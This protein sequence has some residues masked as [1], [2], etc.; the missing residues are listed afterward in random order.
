MVGS[1]IQ[2]QTPLTAGSGQ[3]QRR[4]EPTTSALFT[5]PAVLPTA[6]ALSLFVCGSSDVVHSFD[7]HLCPV[8][9]VVGQFP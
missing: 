5:P 9:C 8:G 6:F 4:P 1:T 2:L 7:L 3:P